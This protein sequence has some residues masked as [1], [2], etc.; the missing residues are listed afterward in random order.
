MS[1]LAL[2]VTEQGFEYFDWNVDSGDAGGTTETDK[3]YENVKNGIIGKRIAVVLQHDTKKFSIDAVEKIIIW[4][5][6]NDYVFLPLTSDS[7]GAH[8]KVFN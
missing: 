7:F 1:R 2:E 4:G 3:V 6:L 5:K 8:H